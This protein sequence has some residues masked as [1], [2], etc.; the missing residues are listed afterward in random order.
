M[1]K[2][3]KDFEHDVIDEDLYEDIDEEEMAELVK[4][5]RQQLLQKQ[6]KPKKEKRKFPKWP[7]WIISIA[8]IINLLAV[9]P[10]TIS[11][12]AIDFLKTS[13]K[14]STDPT[15]KQ[16]K[17]A[18]TVIETDDSKGTGFSISKDGLILTNEHVVEGEEIVT[19]AFPDEGLFSGHVIET[20]P[21]IDLAVVK[22]ETDEQLPSLTL[23]DATVFSE[24]ESIY[25]IGNPLSFHGIANEG[26]II[27]YIQLKGWD[28]PVLMLDAPVYRGNSGSPVINENGEVIGVVFA[29]LHHDVEG[30]VGLFVPIDYYYEQTEK[31][32]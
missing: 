1:S 24:D 14:L 29:T 27:D 25:F 17:K 2:K 7:V 32:E 15:I 13:A 11:I 3:N 26:V 23:A 31:W 22:V 30:R 5:G 6:Q 18:V 20:Y 16:Y 28:E 4:E 12:P 8:L 9:L 21:Q 19:V 10:Q